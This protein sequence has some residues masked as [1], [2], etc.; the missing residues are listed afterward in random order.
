MQVSL[1][2]VPEVVRRSA[3]VFQEEEEGT[4]GKREKKIKRDKN[5]GCLEEA[6]G[7]NCGLAF[8]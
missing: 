7:S 6:S 5:R 2:S 1:R 8:V 3:R 4:S